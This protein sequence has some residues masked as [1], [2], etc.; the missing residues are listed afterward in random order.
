[1]R[2]P[3]PHNLVALVIPAMAAF[4]S[5]VGAAGQ[6]APVPGPTGWDHAA[7][8]SLLGAPDDVDAPGA[9]LIPAAR[10][11]GAAFLASLVLP[12]SGQAGLGLRRWMVYAG[13]EA[14]LWVGYVDTQLD[15]GRL[16][17]AY[18]DLAWSAAR[19]PSEGPRLD[20]GWG[21]YE[22]MSQYIS[23]GAYDADPAAAGV[24][25]ETDGGTYNGN[26]WELA[27]AIYLPGGAVDPTVPEYALAMAYYNDRAIGPR[28]LWT[29]AGRGD[30]MERFRRLIADADAELRLSTTALGLILANHLV[31]SVDALIVSRLRSDGTGPQARLRSGIEPGLP[32]RWRLGVD[33]FLPLPR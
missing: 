7:P 20:G 23:S 4:L 14:L 9:G 11:P 25:P 12:G 6:A 5:A 10:S 26:I 13:L 24:Q 30:D 22:A 32:V 8:T 2:R 28:Y 21:Y 19:S 18:R 1:M 31:S 15:A 27:R 17:E 3:R 33:L 29:W 16:G